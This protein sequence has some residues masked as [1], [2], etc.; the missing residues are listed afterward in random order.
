MQTV[1]MLE[2]RQHARE[3]VER[4]RRG[5]RFVLTYRGRPT[6][7]IEPLAD[8][9]G[10]RENDAFYRLAELAD[11]AGEAMSNREMDEAIYGT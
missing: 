2:L 10:V 5:Q 7:R 3:I 9:D 4:V 1:S 11:S 8:A 6:A